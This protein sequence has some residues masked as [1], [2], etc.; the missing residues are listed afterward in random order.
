MSG[1]E[2]EPCPMEVEQREAGGTSAFDAASSIPL[3][4]IAG[5]P[6]ALCLDPLGDLELVRELEYDLLLLP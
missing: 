1:F 5:M 2:G 3:R 4:V 6:L